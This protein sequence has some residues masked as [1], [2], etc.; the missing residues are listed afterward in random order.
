MMIFTKNKIENYYLLLPRLGVHLIMQFIESVDHSFFIY[1]F[2]V[3]TSQF[4]LRVDYLF[5][6]IENPLYCSAKII[7]MRM[8]KSYEEI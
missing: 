4:F 2:C 7:I 1:I 8:K 6:T 5:I 3:V